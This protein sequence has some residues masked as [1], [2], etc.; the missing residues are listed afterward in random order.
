MPLDPS[1]VI[2]GT[3]GQVYKEGKELA[4]FNRLEA[5]VE[6]QKRELKL[7]GNEWVTHKKGALKGTGTLSGYKVT[8]DAIIQGFEKFELVSKLADPEA[9]GHERIRLMNVMFDR[10]QL[11]NWT[12]HE[13]V[14][15]ELPFTFEGAELLDPITEDGGGA[16][17]TITLN[18]EV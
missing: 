15:E 17:L 13:E 12:A 5:V 8:S 1:R 14:L 4:N 3:Y 11:A 18:L 7:A 6:I 9:Y 10:I 16:S 2:S